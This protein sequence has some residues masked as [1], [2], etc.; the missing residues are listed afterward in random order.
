MGAALATLIG[1]GSPDSAWDAAR[2]AMLT[3]AVGTAITV[4]NLIYLLTQIAIAVDDCDV[5]TGVFRMSRLVFRFPREIGVIFGVVLTLLALGTAASLLAA[6]ALGLIAF[7]PFVGL[8][9]LPLQLAAWA[10]R[11]LVFQFVGLTALAAY[12]RLYRL[13]ANTA[14]DSAAGWLSRRRPWF[15]HGRA[16]QIAERCGGRLDPR[17]ERQEPVLHRERDQARA[18]SRS[19]RPECA[20]HR[21]LRP[22]WRSTTPARR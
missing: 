1:V 16:R 2:I 9:A 11:G 15:C 19:S 12:L 13:S 7:V 21:P 22:R 3:A 10:V 4:I 14:A 17:A 6:A 5:R 18:T 20:P 8:A